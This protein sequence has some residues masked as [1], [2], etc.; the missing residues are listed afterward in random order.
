MKRRFLI[1][2]SLTVL[3]LWSAQAA[4]A[5]TWPPR[6]YTA[7]RL[8]SNVP[9]SFL[10]RPSNQVLE[11]VYVAG[12]STQGVGQAW[13]QQSTFTPLLL[14]AATVPGIATGTVGQD[15]SEKDVV[16]GTY[17]QGAALPFAT[18]WLGLSL[19]SVTPLLLHSSTIGSASVIGSLAYG[20]CTTPL[21]TTLVAGTAYLTATK[22]RAVRFEFTPLGQVTSRALLSTEDSEGFD[23]D[24]VD[25]VGYRI[26]ALQRRATLYSGSGSVLDL[27]PLNA[28]T[29]ELRAT[30]QGQHGGLGTFEGGSVRALLWPERTSNRVVSLHPLGFLQSQVNDIAVTTSQSRSLQAGSGELV[31][32]GTRR[33]HALAWSGTAA[34][35]VD[36]HTY[37]GTNDIAATDSVALGLDQRGNI[38]GYAI[39]PT[40]ERIPIR[41]RRMEYLNTLSFDRL[42]VSPG[43]SVRATVTLTAPA[44][45]TGATISLSSNS[46]LIAPAQV[47]VPAGEQQVTFTVR[48]ALILQRGTGTLTAQYGG[49]TRT[50]SIVIS[51]PRGL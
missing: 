43:S 13:V 2:R 17:I 25:V 22:P 37:L 18:A 31:V 48:A 27:H 8:P 15:I 46:Y 19:P 7:E 44:P 3:A 35:A 39:S 50:T 38:T 26:Q 9:S 10:S 14:P 28:I 5:Q 16:G 42:S 4:Q 6:P 30:S 45:V 20:A 23:T 29:S 36:L 41:W 47:V 12:G 49:L 1:S 32:Q 40:G 24:G 33:T 11:S 51:G 21:G 34:S